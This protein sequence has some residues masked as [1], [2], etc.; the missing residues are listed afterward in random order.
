MKS[1]HLCIQQPN[2]WIMLY[3]IILYCT[4]LY[5][6]VLYCTV[7][8]CDVLCSVS[9]HIVLNC[10]VLYCI[11]L[12]CI[13]LYC[14]VLDLTSNRH[15]EYPSTIIFQAEFHVQIVYGS[16]HFFF[17]LHPFW[18]FLKYHLLHLCYTLFF[19]VLLPLCFCFKDL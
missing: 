17:A 11:V 1:V 19:F 2:S 3:F 5:C 9:Y 15:T 12:F 6:T 16:S 7:L 4:V 13:V 18:L 8:Y 14:I 10:I